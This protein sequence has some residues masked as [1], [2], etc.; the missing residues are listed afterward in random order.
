MA[1][2]VTF[3]EAFNCAVFINFVNWWEVV[4]Q[5]SEHLIEYLNKDN[6]HTV[7]GLEWKDSFCSMN[8][9]LSKCRDIPL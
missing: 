6:I 1:G 8:G 7:S 2:V 4:E 9:G 3:V 5:M